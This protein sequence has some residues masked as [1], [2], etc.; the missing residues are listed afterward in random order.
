MKRLQWINIKFIRRSFILLLAFIVLQIWL[1]RLIWESTIQQWV[2]ES[3]VR[4]PAFLIVYK[5]LSILV[6][7]LSWSV[8]YLIAGW[9]FGTWYG[10]LYAAIWNFFGMTLAY[11]IGRRYWENAI[12]RFLWKKSMH[13][14]TTLLDHLQDKK[15]FIVSRVI[16]MPIEDL[17]NFASGIAKVPYWWFIMT[18]MVI[19]TLVSWWI[20]L[21]WDIIM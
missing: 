10:L 13:Q 7:P 6:A 8:M 3:W 5:A 16:L 12:Q 15:T 20:I 21:V 17:I 9:L 1:S 18:S 14:I 4:A 19:V 2:E 11:W